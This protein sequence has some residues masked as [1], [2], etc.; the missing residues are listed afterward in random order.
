MAKKKNDPAIE[1]SQKVIVA[2][3]NDTLYRISRAYK[4]GL[5]DLKELNPEISTAL[6]R[7]GTKVKIG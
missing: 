3:Y 1:T 5:T 6:I 2:T 4:I 7:K